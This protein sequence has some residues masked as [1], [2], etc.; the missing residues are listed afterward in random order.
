MSCSSCE[1]FDATVELHSPAQ[2]AHVIEKIGAGVG[3]PILHYQSFESDQKPIGQ[4]SFAAVPAN[5]PWPD[6]MRAIIS[7]AARAR[8]CTS[9]NR[10]RITGL[11]ALGGLIPRSLLTRPQPIAFG[12]G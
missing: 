3:A 12:R 2:L 8:P 6:V 10:R 1:Q 9:S 11:V 5:G 4:P 7:F